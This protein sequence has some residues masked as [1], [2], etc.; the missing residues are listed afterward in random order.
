MRRSRSFLI[1][2]KGQASIEYILLLAL[3]LAIVLILTREIIRP[4]YDRLLAT[5]GERFEKN[6]FNN[7]HH[8]RI[9]R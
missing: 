9:G 7:L 2:Q 5:V 4:A 1:D 3:A 8:F 6:L